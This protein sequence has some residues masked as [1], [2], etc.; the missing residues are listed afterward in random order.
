MLELIKRKDHDE[1]TELVVKTNNGEFC[2]HRCEDG[3]MQVG[4]EKDSIIESYVISPENIDIYS[5]FSTLYKRLYNGVDEEAITIASKE[6]SYNEA[7]YLTIAIDKESRN[8]IL[9][10][11][12]S[13]SSSWRNHSWVTVP[14]ELI[15]IFN[16]LY[17]GLSNISD[18]NNQMSISEYV[19]IVI[20]DLVRTRT[21]LSGSRK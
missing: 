2:I 1:T 14:D 8:I 13:N 12:R 18:V 21:I 3:N 9:T 16:E 10:L 19:D 6:F 11:T 15:P 4:S 7:S 20:N 5:K 17:E